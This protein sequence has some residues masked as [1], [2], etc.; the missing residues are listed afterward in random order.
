MGPC[1]RSHLDDRLQRIRY[2][3]APVQHNSVVDDGARTDETPA[4]DAATEHR[5][6]E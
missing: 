4:D 1:D 3:H 6:S 5:A 2:E